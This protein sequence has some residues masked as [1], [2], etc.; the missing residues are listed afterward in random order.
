MVINKVSQALA[1]DSDFEETNIVE[2]W[3][4]EV[5]SCPL[6]QAKNCEFL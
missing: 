3:P 5:P 2:R 1:D 6:N 4:M